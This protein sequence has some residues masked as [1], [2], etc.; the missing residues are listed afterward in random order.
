MGLFKVWRKL[1]MSFTKMREN[2]DSE[3]HSKSE[4][5]L[6]KM[7]I[8]VE[9]LVHLTHNYVQETHNLVPL[10]IVPSAIKDAVDLIW[11]CGALKCHIHHNSY[12]DRSWC[13][14]S[15]LVG[16]GVAQFQRVLSVA[17]EVAVIDVYSLNDRK[18]FSRRSAITR[19]W[20]SGCWTQL[21]CR[22]TNIT[23]TAY[24]VCLYLT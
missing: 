2:S 13:V 3:I 14:Q 9:W 10:L 19:R 7:W 8:C 18:T 16:D 4:S 21:V 22:L 20:V 17:V 24:S 11:F 23:S 15:S 1:D 6:K 5:I 12:V